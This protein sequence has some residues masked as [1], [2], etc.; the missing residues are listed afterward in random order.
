MTTKP[1]AIATSFLFSAAV[2]PAATNITLVQWGEDVG[3]TDIVTSTQSV[4][5]DTTFVSADVDSP[6]VGASYYPNA[7]G[8]NP[9][10]N[11]AGSD[12]SWSINVE[13]DAAGDSI[14]FAASTNS[15]TDSIVIWENFSPMTAVLDYTFNL[16][17]SATN[18]FPEQAKYGLVMQDGAG[19]WYIQ[20]NT[21]FWGFDTSNVNA[22]DITWYD[23]TPH[24]NGAD[25]IGDEPKSPTIAGAQAFGYRQFNSFGANMEHNVSYFQ[26]MAVVPEPSSTALLGLGG[27]VMALRRKRG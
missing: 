12:N 3:A 27:L 1:L 20:G 8:R 4:T 13:N 23:Y 14:T 19:D 10:F 26:V 15:N 25:P 9:D 17:S 21:T 7:S 11:V 24:S 5:T 2:L 6:T 22:S 16:N 18:G